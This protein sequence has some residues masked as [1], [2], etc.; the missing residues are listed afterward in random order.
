[1]RPLK[2]L[3]P[4][5]DENL[6]GLITFDPESDMTIIIIYDVASLLTRTKI[7]YV[8]TFIMGMDF[9]LVLHYAWFGR[10]SLYIA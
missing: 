5:P 3:L 10:I 4:D 8:Y 7:N 1:M 2:R 9:P 6:G